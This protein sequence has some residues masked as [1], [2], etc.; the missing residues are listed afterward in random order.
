VGVGGVADAGGVAAICWRF[1]SKLALSTSQDWDS[2]SHV[3]Q[4]SF[5]WGGDPQH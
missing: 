1:W 4:N 3:S 5:T 2:I